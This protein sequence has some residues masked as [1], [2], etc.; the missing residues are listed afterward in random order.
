[1]VVAVFVLCIALGSF[2]VGIA[3]R[4]PHAALAICQWSLV[5]LLYVLYA[6]L[7]H[8]PYAAHVLRSLFRD[9]DAAFYAYYVALLLS[10]LILIGPVVVLSGATLPL[11]FDHLRRR[12]DDLGHVA[13]ALYSW[14]TVGSLLG[15]LLGGYA[16]LFWF[17][18]DQVY[19]VALFAQAVAALL[20]GWQVGGGARRLSP[21]IAAVALIGIVGIGRWEPASFAFG[22][23][24]TRQPIPHSYE[25]RDAMLAHFLEKVD[26]VFYTDDPIQSVAVT[27]QEAESGGLSRSIVNNG[28]S[29]GNTDIDYP[30]MG[31]LALL[32]AL[33]ANQTE[34]AFVIGFGTGV[35]VG[36]LMVLPTMERVVVSEISPG[37]LEAAPLFD[38]AN[39]GVTRSE[40]VEMLRTDAYRALIGS[41][42]TFDVIV[43]E[44]SNPW[45]QGIEMLFSREFLEAARDRLR[46][47][48]VYAQWYH[49]YETDAASVELVLR[50]YA[51]VFDR[52][53]VWYGFGP[54]LI[55]LGFQDGADP[56]DIE[57]LARRAAEPA[58]RA[59]LARSGV[60]SLAELLAHEI[61]PL[62][63][64]QAAALEG[65]I[66]S[67]YKPILGYRAARAFYRGSRG[68]LP[69]SGFGDAARIGRRNALL[70]RYPGAL[71][72]KDLFAGFCSQ[73]WTDC[74]ALL[75]RWE[76]AVPNAE[77]TAVRVRLAN[78]QLGGG[79]TTLTV[80][81]VRSVA[82]LVGPPPD[83]PSIE[84]IPLE[85]AELATRQYVRLYSHVLP[86]SPEA[87]RDLWRRC[88]D[89]PD[90]AGACATGRAEAA[91]LLADGTPPTFD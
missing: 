41:D 76:R 15:A 63:V 81:L 45:V 13:G 88:V 23:F 31:L 24:R 5:A 54:D 2:G 83:D 3:K 68:E 60:A 73:R 75:A 71:H 22:L 48:G 56:L 64:A 39:Q 11:I 38:F 17:D 12:F 84:P 27:E 42:E 28:K 70:A 89:P 40:K 87:L 14:N 4:I 34:S 77:A 30:T 35:S 1:M 72:P 37:V 7:P 65:P 74:V 32:P 49:Q 66:H 50:T 86:F 46:P 85:E 79:G 8:A 21:W 69:F 55:L 53:S 78:E 91:R 20:L 25:G 43:S 82:R 44:P 19:G 16:L 36:E 29:D 58:Y 80:P 61:L 90:R 57:R 6:L 67:L 47:G 59:G 10:I 52:V 51:A 9:V 33:L 26:L 18:L 62:G